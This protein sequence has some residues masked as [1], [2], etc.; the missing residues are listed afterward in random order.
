MRKKLVF[1]ALLIGVFLF[2]I[3]CTATVSFESSWFTERQQPSHKASVNEEPPAFPLTLKW[4]KKLEGPMYSSPIVQISE[5]NLYIGSDTGKLWALNRTTGETKWVFQARGKIRTSAAAITVQEGTVGCQPVNPQKMLFVTST[6]GDLYSINP[7][8]GQEVWSIKPEGAG[9]FISSPTY[10]NPTIFYVYQPGFSARLKAVKARTGEVLWETDSY[11]PQNASPS[12]GHGSLYLGKLSM[13]LSLCAINPSNGQVRDELVSG[14]ENMGAYTSGVPDYD[15]PIRDE[16]CQ[17][18]GDRL[19]IST[20][21]GIVS[22]L[23]IPNN[24]ERAAYE[25]ETTLP[26]LDDIT[27]FSLTSGRGVSNVLVVSQHGGLYAMDALTGD[28]QWRYSYHEGGEIDYI[29]PQPA[30]W[31]S[32]VFH[33]IVVESTGK[34]RIVALSLSDG[35][36]QWGFDLDVGTFSSPVIAGKY[37]YITDVNGTIY[38]FSGEPRKTVEPSSPQRFPEKLYMYVASSPNVIKRY[39]G[40]TGVFINDF[41]IAPDNARPIDIEVGW[42]YLYVCYD[43]NT[44]KRFDGKTGRY[45]DDFVSAGSGGLYGA[46]CVRLGPDKNLYVSSMWNS[47]I[48]RYNGTTGEYID[49]F[50]SGGGLARPSWMWFWKDGLYVCSSL[51][52]EIKIYD[53]D[54]G[55]FIRNFVAQDT[56]TGLRLGI[57]GLYG[58]LGFTFKDGHLYVASSFTDEIKQ[59]DDNGLFIN[60]FITA[61]SGGLKSPVD[62][63]FV[64]NYLYV[65]SAGTNEIKRYDSETGE[66]LGNIVEPCGGKLKS[67]NGIRV[68]IT[69]DSSGVTTVPINPPTFPEIPGTIPSINYPS[70]P[71]SK[72]P[73]RVIP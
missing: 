4:K 72:S 57:G 70:L 20:K 3:S 71:P 67:P 66:Y 55:E 14:F 68:V 29:S 48:I 42:G 25:W 5:G 26:V 45:I 60:N 8:T 33:P 17:I 39:D 10:L 2:I 65:T 15:R 53:K 1:C 7:I 47:K 73:Y 6:A 63:Q 61:G 36:E 38:A 64:G 46:T 37:L 9:P 18:I 44:V 56:S 31:G 22:C 58:P 19:Y 34:P 23:K 24:A 11:N 50:I 40:W 59:Y 32:Y 12:V 69:P 51:S 54:T 30:I 62:V 41:A 27:G 52:N 28:I 35:T 21:R 49:D 13:G 43:N 16:N